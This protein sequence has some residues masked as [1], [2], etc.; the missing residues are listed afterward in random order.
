MNNKEI[1][2]SVDVYWSVGAWVAISLFLLADRWFGF[3]PVEADGVYV[4]C[5][6][7]GLLA[8]FDACRCYKAVRKGGCRIA[9]AVDLPWALGLLASVLWLSVSAQ[10]SALRQIEVAGLLDTVCFVL[11]LWFVFGLLGKRKYATGNGDATAVD[12]FEYT[13]SADAGITAL[14]MARKALSY[15]EYFSL[16]AFLAVLGYVLMEKGYTVVAAVVF[17]LALVALVVEVR[18]CLP[19]N[20][21]ATRIGYCRPLGNPVLDVV[22]IGL[23]I[24]TT[25]IGPM[26]LGGML[27]VFFLADLLLWTVTWRLHGHRPTASAAK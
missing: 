11:N 8:A 17:V 2:F 10:I 14:T 13:L 23:G 7:F 27:L 16:V 5:M 25:V 26:W 4:C 1:R 15:I 20:S 3:L 21:V 18:M 24:A 19:R 22:C 12:A 6:T 9:A